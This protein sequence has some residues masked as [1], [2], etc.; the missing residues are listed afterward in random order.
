MKCPS[1]GHENPP[2]QKFCGE[3]GARAELIC[4]SCQAR[5]PPGQ[6][7]CGECG[8]PLAAGRPPAAAPVEPAVPRG[9]RFASPD[10]YT[11]K[12]LADKILTSRGALEGERKIV[13]VMFADVSGF[14]SMSERLDPE[15]VHAIMD[16]AFDVILSAVHRY[17]GTINQFLGDGVMALF[18]APIAHEDHAPRALNAALDIQKSLGPL[19]EEVRRL[20]AVEF[21]MRMGINTGLVV[22]GAIGKDLRMDYTAVGDTTNLAARLMALATPGQIVLSE[23]THR[24]R[25]RVFTFDDLGEHAVKGKAEPVRAY[26]LTGVS[27]PQ[28]RLEVTPERGLTPLVGRETELGH[29]AAAYESAVDGQGSVV[30]LVGEPGAGKSRLLYEFLRGLD[31]TDTME[32]ETICVSY[33]R[34]IAYRPILELLRRY[35]GLAEG[36]TADDVRRRTGERLAALGLEGEEPRVLLAHLL[37]APA[38][39][40]FLSRV[41]AAELKERTLHLLRDVFVKASAAAPVVLVVENVHWADASSLEVLAHLVGDMAGHRI[42]LTLSARPGFSV[43]WL[44]PTTAETIHLKPLHTGDM[45]AMIR[46]MLGAVSISPSLLD[47]L[48]GK[49]EGNPLYVEELILQLRETNGIVVTH[50]EARLGS[51]D[52]KVPATIQDI[53]AARVDRLE[54]GLKLAL[55]GAGV[56]GR[57]FGVSLLSRVVELAPAE[58]GRRLRE[59]H[60]FDFVFPSAEDPELMYSFKHALTQDVVYAGLLERRRRQYHRAAGVGLEAL[61]AAHLDDVVELLVYHFGRSGN[62]DKAVDYGLAAAEKAQRRWANAEALAFFEEVLRRLTSMPDTEANRLRRIDAGVKQA[63]L[64]FALGRHA[65]HV[66]ALAALRE[67]VDSTADP[68]RQASWYYWTG[69][70]HSLTGARPDI[71]IGY[72]QTAARIAED[73]GLEEIRAAADSC[74]GQV[75]AYAGRLGEALDAGERALAVFEARG[76]VWW[77][78]RTLWGL[79]LTAIPLADWARSLDYCRRAL[80]YG[81]DVNDRRLLVVGWWRSGWTHIQRGDAAHGIECCERAL[82]LSPGPYDTAMARA[83]MGYGLV[84]VGRIDEGIATLQSAV[85]WFRT[86]KL[87]FTGAWYAIWLADSHLRRGDAPAARQLAEETLAK[88]RDAGYRYFEGLAER[89]LG[90][91][92]VGHDATAAAEHLQAALDI[93]APAGVRN[94]VAKILVAQAELRRIAGDH[95]CARALLEKALAMFEALGTLDEPSRVRDLLART[96]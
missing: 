48:V 85:D 86:S 13:T 50:G 8:A 45:E 33:G 24:L 23:R 66:Q 75:Y 63:E 36:L 62:D 20:H 78:C 4:T 49:G 73:A 52:V 84:K 21:R 91:A 59:L 76:N 32:L 71:S 87:T 72:C 19:A 70:L 5:N 10:A 25:D 79:S 54:D 3:C 55:Q 68:P 64:M 27:A 65:E 96:V 89:L 22:V 1:C 26:A 83:S 38:P 80:A 95:A 29:L 30:L 47:L 82:A 57:R 12:H 17:E 77:S 11:P 44:S 88:S 2:A 56:I 35:L 90:T 31:D 61:Y 69:F 81:Q 51:A 41:S 14:T 60:G 9:D 58:T 67:I 46:A 94:D 92:L 6:K 37:G 53:I 34:T 16:R 40:E 7:F 15:D 43:P 28:K 93:L 39:P 18:G 42:L 74:L